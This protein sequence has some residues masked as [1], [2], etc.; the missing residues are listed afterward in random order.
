MAKDPKT[1]TLS[2]TKVDTFNGCKRLFLY[3]YIKQPFV[4]PENKFFLIGNVVHKAL[5]L[6]HKNNSPMGKCFKEA[7]AKYD[8]KRKLKKGII[9]NSDLW[10]IKH[11]LINYLNHLKQLPK[12]PK[13]HMVE[14]LTK[15][16]IKGITVWLKADRIDL[17]GKN[18]Y[19]VIDY[20]S[21]K[22]M[23]K[24]NELDSVQIHSYGIL[25]RQKIHPKAKIYGDYFYLKF[26][27]SKRGIHSH[28]ITNK[29]MKE[30][31]KQYVK[32]DKALKN[33]CKFTQNFK[34]KYCD[35]CE[36]RKLC[37]E[38]TNDDL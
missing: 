31:I 36:F 1:L 18:R 3:K 37:L 7:I 19:K 28:K 26:M 32:V 29:W 14:E 22:P 15:L 6:Y 24:A 11:M 12:A 38:D 10:T 9:E 35:L 21:G 20:K 17:I 8:A 5:E 2:P 33:G 30:A 13:V 34:Y 25:V 23:S 16:D 27:D 4:P